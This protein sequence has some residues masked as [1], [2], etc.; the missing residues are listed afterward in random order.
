VLT[1]YA[2]LLQVLDPDQLAE[3]ITSDV[4]L[5]QMLPE[6]LGGRIRESLFTDIQIDQIELIVGREVIKTRTKTFCYRTI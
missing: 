6:T 1:R 4:Y 3:G 5:Y 2:M